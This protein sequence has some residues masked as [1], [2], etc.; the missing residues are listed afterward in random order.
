MGFFSSMTSYPTLFDVE[1]VAQFPDIWVNLFIVF[2]IGADAAGD[3][4]H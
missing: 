1:V 4:Y 2:L 3:T